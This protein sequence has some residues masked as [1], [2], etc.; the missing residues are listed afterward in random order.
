MREQHQQQQSI[1]GIKYRQIS[2]AIDSGG[3]SLFY[4]LKEK[5]II[6]IKTKKL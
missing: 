1:I 5:K 4:Q 3:N 2:N 6:K